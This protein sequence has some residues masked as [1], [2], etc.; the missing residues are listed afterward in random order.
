MNRIPA[1]LLLFYFI[2][3][4]AVASSLYAGVQID[5]N[6]A[7]VLFGYP[8]NKTYAVE[9][10]YTKSS[11]RIEHAGVTVDTSSNGIGIVGIAAFPMRLNDVLPYS[12][13]VK[14]G[15]ERT[16]NTD[17]CSIPTSATLTQPYD[18]TI[19]SHKNQVIFGGGAEFDLAK[20]LTG[21]FGLDFL[22]NKRSLNLAVILKF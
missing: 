5:D 2:A 7:G 4:P 11:S 19:T 13:F 22:G 12:L 1:A 21:R 10:H 6:S 18:N 15:Y 8:L 20:S 16:T 9:A 3:T 14:G 17:T